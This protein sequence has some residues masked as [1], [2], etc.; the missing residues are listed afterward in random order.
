MQKSLLR[1]HGL[2]A[3]SDFGVFLHSL[4]ALAT[5]ALRFLHF[6]RIQTLRQLFGEIFWGASLGPVGLRHRTY[7]LEGLV[8]AMNPCSGCCCRKH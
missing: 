7:G 4:E 5:P 1:I 6:N 3:A 8:C 2:T